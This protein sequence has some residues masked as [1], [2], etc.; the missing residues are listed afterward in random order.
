M[1]HFIGA[2]AARLLGASLL[3]FAGASA[4]W[5]QVPVSSDP[6]EITSCLCQQ[7]GVATLSAD[8]SAKTQALATI[9]QQL[10][11]LD[12]QLARARPAVDVNNPDSVARYKALL[13]QRDAAY[14]Q[15]IGPVVAA[16]DQATAR[17]NSHVSAYNAGC[18]SRMFDAEIMAQIQA[19]L[20][21][22]PLQ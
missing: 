14:Q 9:R 18:A 12:S 21:C 13:A 1:G 16:A 4:A 8:M 10:A 17:Y 5:A 7:Q 22:P 11:D 19:H 6:A 20:A 3:G 15:S 2:G